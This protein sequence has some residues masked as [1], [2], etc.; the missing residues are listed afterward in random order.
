MCEISEPVTLSLYLSTFTFCLIRQPRGGGVLF[1][2]PS[3]AKAEGLGVSA[4]VWMH[5][6]VV[7]PRRALSYRSDGYFPC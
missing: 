3:G 2:V 5:Q 4:E 6:T 7:S 1:I